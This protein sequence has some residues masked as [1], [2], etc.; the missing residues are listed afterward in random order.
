M[1]SEIPRESFSD[2]D[3]AR[4]AKRLQEHLDALDLVLARPDFGTGPITANPGTVLRLADPSNISGNA[5]TILSDGAG[6]VNSV[7]T[8]PSPPPKVRSTVPS[9]L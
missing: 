1:S 5:V 7:V 4:F 9:G 6:V 8:N 3:H 2:A